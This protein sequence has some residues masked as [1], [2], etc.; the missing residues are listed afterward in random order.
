MKTGDLPI[1]TGG[2]TLTRRRFV[3]VALAMV[4]G[5]LPSALFAESAADHASALFAVL[6]EP[7]AAVRFGRAY[8]QGHPTESDSAVL[9]ELLSSALGTQDGALPTTQESLINALVNLVQN[10]YA[11]GPLLRVNGWL[12][13]PSEARLYALAS[14]ASTTPRTR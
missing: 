6:T 3:A 13:A 8:L 14:L 5:G 12:L 2:P 7:G 1:P 4:G 10:E 11:N 9:T